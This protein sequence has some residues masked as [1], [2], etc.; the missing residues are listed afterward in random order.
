MVKYCNGPPKA[1]FFTL[2]HRQLKIKASWEYRHDNFTEK[3]MGTSVNPT[4]FHVFLLHKLTNNDSLRTMNNKQ[5][6]VMPSS[7]IKALC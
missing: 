3:Y 2:F 4:I 1:H 7:H 5:Q 6:K